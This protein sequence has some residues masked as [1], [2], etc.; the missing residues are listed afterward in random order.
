MRRKR[1]SSWTHQSDNIFSSQ[2]G[3]KYSLLGFA[4]ASTANN[5]AAFYT[6]TNAI[7]VY[8]VSSALQLSHQALTVPLTTSLSIAAIHPEVTH[9]HE[10]LQRQTLHRR[11]YD[12]CLGNR[13]R[14]WRCVF[15]SQN[16]LPGVADVS[17]SQCAFIIRETGYMNAEMWPP[18]SWTSTM[19]SAIKAIDGNH[20][21]I[22]GASRQ[23]PTAPRFRNC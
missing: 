1:A 20:L 5:G 12:P 22:D 7:N 16:G 15:G 9:A 4:G 23:R 17:I 3:G 18:A 10:R 8:K 14:A 21:I 11:P 13:Q 19:V 6:D 2:H